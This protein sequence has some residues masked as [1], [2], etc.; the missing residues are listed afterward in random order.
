MRSCAPARR[1]RRAL[2]SSLGVEARVIRPP[3]DLDVFVPDRD[4]RAER[5]TVVCPPAAEG[6]LARALERVRSRLP[7][8]VLSP[9]SEGAEAKAIAT[10]YQGA[11]VSVQPSV[12]DGSGLALLE[13]LACGTP[14][15]GARAGAA[16]EI[17]DS[18]LGATFGEGEHDLAEALLAALELSGGEACAPVCRARA[19]EHSGTA[20]A[21]STRRSTGS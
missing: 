21:R 7:D 5:P 19:E 17:V 10:A 14:V 13:S 1:P 16:A 8:V 2:H 20:C 3:V 11:W 6:L 15:V 4:R 9:V 12:R 18:G